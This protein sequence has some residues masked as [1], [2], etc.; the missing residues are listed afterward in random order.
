MRGLGA[1]EFDLSN[2]LTVPIQ[3]LADRFAMR[4][5]GGTERSFILAVIHNKRLLRLV[6]D[7]LQLSHRRIEDSEQGYQPA[8]SGLNPYGFGKLSKTSVMNSRVVT[9]SAFGTCPA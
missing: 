3:C 8:R 1:S 5:G 4:R 2:F 9:V 6:Q 7:F